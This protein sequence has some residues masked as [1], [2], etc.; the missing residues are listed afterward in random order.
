MKLKKV[1]KDTQEFE[2][3]SNAIFFCHFSGDD[4]YQECFTIEPS[5]STF[6]YRDYPSVIFDDGETP[7]RI[8]FYD[9]HGRIYTYE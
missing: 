8:Y 3:V 1:P 5:G 9:R 4:E 2:E 7:K 6:P